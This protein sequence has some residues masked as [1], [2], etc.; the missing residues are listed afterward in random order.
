MLIETAGELIPSLCK[1]VGGP[2]F[3]PYFDTIFSQL[4]KKLVLYLD[5]TMLLT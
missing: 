4:K 5:I 2:A 1:L 3:A